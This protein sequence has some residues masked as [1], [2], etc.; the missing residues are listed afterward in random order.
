V[1]LDVCDVRVMEILFLLDVQQQLRDLLY[2]VVGFL[3]RLQKDIQDRSVRG[4]VG[5]WFGA[6][7]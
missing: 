4:V 7:I 1:S 2:R 3:L 5:L 6:S